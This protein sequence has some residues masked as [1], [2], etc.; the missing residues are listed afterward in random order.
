MLLFAVRRRHAEPGRIYPFSC[1]SPR[2]LAVRVGDAVRRHALCYPLPHGGPLHLSAPVLRVLPNPSG[3]ERK[4]FIAHAL[5]MEL[6]SDHRRAEEKV[7]QR[8]DALWQEA[9]ALLR[10]ELATA[11]E[12]PPS[13]Q[14]SR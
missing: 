11:N 6:P 5:I 9:L 2:E 1:P 13:P 14:E 3:G 8:A 10:G 12:I 7:A 4:P